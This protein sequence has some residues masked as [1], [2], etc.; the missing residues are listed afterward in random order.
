M[1]MAMSVGM[2]TLSGLQR[3]RNSLSLS[4]SR[5]LVIIIIITQL[6]A[7]SRR[8][9]NGA[10][11]AVKVAVLLVRAMLIGK[12]EH[13]VVVAAQVGGA[14]AV[15][16]DLGQGLQAGVAGAHDGLA[17]VV[18]AVVAVVLDLV[19]RVVDN[20]VRVVGEPEEVE[21]V[22]LVEHGDAVHLVR[23]GVVRSRER[24]VQPG[25]LLVGDLDD[26][27]SGRHH[28]LPHL[29]CVVVGFAA[30][31]LVR[32]EGYGC[33]EHDYGRLSAFNVCIQNKLGLLT[34]WLKLVLLGPALEALELCVDARPCCKTG[35]EKNNVGYQQGHVPV[36]K[37]PDKCSFLLPPEKATFL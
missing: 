26:A 27:V 7:V 37:P 13:A 34:V 21:A 18:D 16:A 19:G 17:D 31:E 11:T 25:R 20:G 28:T 10:S 15:D 32:L 14:H 3:I 9:G 22:Q 29:V 8:V 6:V 33:V 30:H 23:L 2:T 5:G 4:R 35:D 1:P 36:G 24:R 12:G